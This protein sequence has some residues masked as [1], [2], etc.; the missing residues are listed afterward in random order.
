MT[1][2]FVQQ[3]SRKTEAGLEFIQFHSE[4]LITTKD[5]ANMIGLKLTLRETLPIFV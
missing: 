1:N 4:N 2:L 3:V 5:I